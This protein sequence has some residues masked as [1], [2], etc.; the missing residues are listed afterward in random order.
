M[1]ILDKIKIAS[2]CSQYWNSMEGDERVRFCT[3][4][5]SNV[6][7][8]ASMSK[9]EAEK[10]IADKCGNVCVMIFKKRDGTVKTKDCQEVKRDETVKTKHYQEEMPT[11][12]KKK[13]VTGRRMGRV[14]F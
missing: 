8:I 10:L 14:I 9:K 1:S 12:T 5:N 2:P 7:N 6:F 11:S 13:V 4:C 3:V